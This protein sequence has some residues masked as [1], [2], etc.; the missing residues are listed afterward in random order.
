MNFITKDVFLA[1]KNIS[2]LIFVTKSTFCCSRVVCWEVVLGIIGEDGLWASLAV[3]LCLSSISS[4]SFSLSLFARLSPKIVWSEN[5]NVNQFPGQSHKTHG[6]MKCFFGKFYFPC[7]TK[8]LMRCKIISW[9]GFT[10][11]QMQP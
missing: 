2:S 9:N 11:K 8:Q 4:F 1:M 6:Q 5:R 7:A 10:P 3:C